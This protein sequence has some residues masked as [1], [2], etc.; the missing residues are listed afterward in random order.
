MLNHKGTCA[1][2]TKRLTLRKFSNYDVTDTYK[3]WATD[4]NIIN[5]IDIDIHL[6]KESTEHFILEHIIE[7]RDNYYCWTIVHNKTNES[8]GSIQLLNINDYT[9][10][11]EIG[12][13]IGSKYWNQGLMTEALEHVLKFAFEEIGFVRIEGYC[14]PEN[15]SSIKVMEKCNMEFE[16]IL[17]KSILINDVYFDG[18]LYAI[19]RNDI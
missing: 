19:V 12:F 13:V 9:K 7:Y 3:N 17:K 18:S 14:K 2:I 11:C 4:V 1:I 15:L 8:I 5:T 6:S 10:K 16:G